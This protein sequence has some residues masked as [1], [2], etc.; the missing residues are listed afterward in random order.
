M[1]TISFAIRRE[2]LEAILRLREPNDFRRAASQRLPGRAQVVT[3]TAG[4]AI[5]CTGDVKHGCC[6]RIVKLVEWVYL[7]ETRVR[8]R[9]KDLGPGSDISNLPDASTTDYLPSDGLLGKLLVNSEVHTASGTT[10]K[11]V[12]GPRLFAEGHSI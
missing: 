9:F 5:R 11:T 1:S 4:V 2:R 6:L 10:T 7:V 3:E 12:F 8:L